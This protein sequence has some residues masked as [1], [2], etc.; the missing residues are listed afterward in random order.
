MDIARLLRPNSLLSRTKRELERLRI[1]LTR[2]YGSIKKNADTFQYDASFEKS[3]RNVKSFRTDSSLA[4]IKRN[5][6][7]LQL[8]GMLRRT[9]NNE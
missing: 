6:K 4:K 1:I 5:F 9:K 8:I 2:N 3:K 7:K